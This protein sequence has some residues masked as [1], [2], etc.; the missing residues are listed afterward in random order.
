MVTEIVGPVVRARLDRPGAAVGEILAIATGDS[1]R[2]RIPAQVVGFSAGQTVL[3]PLSHLRGIGPYS[4]VMKRAPGLTVACSE[5]L[6]GRVLD[7]LGRPLDDGPDLDP[8]AEPWAVQGPAPNP[9]TCPLIERSLATG[10][11]AIDGLTTLGRGQRIGLF[12]GPGVGKSSLLARIADGADVD[13]CVV[14]L[15][16]ERARDIRAFVRTRL[17]PKS[18]R[19]TIFVCAPSDAPSAVRAQ[20][21]FVATAI[22]EWWCARRA[23]HALL[24]VDSLTRYARAQRELGLAA[25]E[26]PGRGGLPASVYAHLPQL[27]ERAGAR[28]HG[29]ITALYSVLTDDERLGDPIAIEVRSLVDGDIALSSKRA[30]RAQWPAIDVLASVSRVMD[31]VADPEHIGAAARVRRLLAVYREHE[32]LLA[33][34]AYRAGSDPLVDAAIAARPAIDAFLCHEGASDFQTCRAQL[35]ELAGRY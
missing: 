9:L 19:R 35:L 11:R 15:V 31:Q 10:V 30:R 14:C 32:P 22:A 6:L 25:G 26:L 8:D 12:S 17:S 27:V 21:P 28:P 4:P 29:S 2:A 3:S 24:V 1:Q 33:M 13:V 7:G 20:A 5:R 16:G 34:G 18:R 23:A